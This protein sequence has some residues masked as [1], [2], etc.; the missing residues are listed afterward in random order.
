MKKAISSVCA[1][2]ACLIAT[3]GCD[4]S[5]TQP[6]PTYQVTLQVDLTAETGGTTPA[7]KV[8]STARNTGGLTVSYV[9]GCP[10]NPFVTLFD[11]DA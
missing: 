11:A 2:L 4:E 9:Y 8:V 10:P 1:L 6:A 3:S 7:I 5:T